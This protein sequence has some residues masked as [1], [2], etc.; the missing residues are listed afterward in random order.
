MF[1]APSCPSSGARGDSA[2][3][4][5]GRL[6]LELLLYGSLCVCVCVCVCVYVCVYIYV[7]VYVY[8][9]IYIYRVFQKDLNDLNLVYFTRTY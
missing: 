7:C 1:Q 2:G 6:V 9:Y 5:I 8:I 3:Y 4:H